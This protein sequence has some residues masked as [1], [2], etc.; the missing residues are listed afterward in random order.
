MFRTTHDVVLW[1]RERE[2]EAVKGKIG[3]QFEGHMREVTNA[4]VAHDMRNI[5]I[6]YRMPVIVSIVDGAR[7]GEFGWLIEA[8]FSARGEEDAVAQLFFFLDN[9][10][11]IKELFTATQSKEVGTI[12]RH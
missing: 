10:S 7:K 2:A 12:Q 5:H 1:I 8:T 3:P 11:F 9:K 4:M 6:D